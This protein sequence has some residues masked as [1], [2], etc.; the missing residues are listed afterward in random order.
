M[1]RTP[2]ARRRIVR[3]LNAA[4]VGELVRLREAA[5]VRDARSADLIAERIVE[6]GGEPDYSFL[7]AAPRVR[8]PR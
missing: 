7:R 5:G 3:R 4:L 6:L 1:T 2:S 8:A